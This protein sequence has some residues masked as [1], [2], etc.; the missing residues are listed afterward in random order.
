MNRYSKEADV[1]IGSVFT[2]LT[3]LE[4]IVTEG[5][6]KATPYVDYVCKCECGN[7][8]KTKGKFLRGGNNK[9]CGCLKK[10]TKGG[11]KNKLKN[12][13]S[14]RNMV[15]GTY[16]YDARARQLEFNLSNEDLDVLFASNCYYC[17]SVPSNRLSHGASVFI[18]TGVDRVDNSK[19]YSEE[20]CVPACMRCNK[21]KLAMTLDN[22]LDHVAKIYFRLSEIRHDISSKRGINV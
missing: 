11:R 4:K 12:G 7:I 5:A 14:S 2:R 13:N 16:K 9:S 15:I 19:G 17:G 20:N 18:Y 8:V 21:A 3:V 6:R 10:D 22:F 1:E